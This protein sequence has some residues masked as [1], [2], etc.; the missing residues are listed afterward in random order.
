[1]WNTCATLEM[2]NYQ[3]LCITATYVGKT[4]TH[5]VVSVCLAV[6]NARNLEEQGGVPL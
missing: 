4:W 3:H 6:Y 2:L 5:V 1:M